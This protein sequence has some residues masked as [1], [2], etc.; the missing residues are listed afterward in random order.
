MDKSNENYTKIFAYL[1]CY[2]GEAVDKRKASGC[3]QGSKAVHSSIHLTLIAIA[4]VGL[5]IARP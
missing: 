5:A 1:G 4:I 2:S 3:F